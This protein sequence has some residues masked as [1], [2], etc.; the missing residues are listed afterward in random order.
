MEKAK[1]QLKTSSLFVLLFAGLSLMNI[2]SAL[3]FGDINSA[4]IPEGAPDNILQI[5]KMLLLIVTAIILLPKVYVGI[6]GLQIAKNPVASKRHI[7][8]AM[9]ILAFEAFGAIDPVLGI[10]KEGFTMEHFTTLAD[11]VLEVCIIYEYIKYAKEVA[12]L[13]EQD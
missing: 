8:V 11:V 2:I 7:T 3:T 5:T 4:T 10:V 6:K 9:L 12:K 13:A 1:K